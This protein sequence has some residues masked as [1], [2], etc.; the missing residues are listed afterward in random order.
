MA[1]ISAGYS[2]GATE[3]VTAAKLG[4]LA[5]SV[6]GTMTVTGINTAD[7]TDSAIT[8]GKISSVAGS[9]FIS[10][11]GVPA[12]SGVIPAA[13]LTSVAQKGA[14]SDITSLSGLT[15]PLSVAQG[16]TAST[17]AADARTALGLAI[18]TDIPSYS[19]ATKKQ[20][21]TASGTFTAPAGVI[22]V[23]L[24]MTGSGGGGG[25]G[26]NASAYEGGGGGGG[27]E[28]VVKY[29]YTV[30]PTSA[31]TVTVGDAGTGGAA[32]TDGIAGGS[33]VF[34]T[35]TMK[36]GGKGLKSG[37]AGGTGAT[38]TLNGGSPTT[39]GIGTFAG[40]NGGTGNNPNGGG[41]GGSMLG[42]GGAGGGTG[43]VGA[44]GTGCGSGGGGGGYNAAGGNG[45][46]GVVLV[47][48]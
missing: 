8:D 43:A 33:V 44:V 34:D 36:G 39:G 23:Y 15:T 40:G 18:G 20:L 4:K 45:S 48:W 1:V 5:S 46:K 41:G 3:E 10:L 38:S 32:V 17:S 35:L 31:Y 6:T 47:E 9:K 24:T 16:G 37:G 21:F 2:F 30:V 19:D 42:L 28:S 22:K 29:P 14:N 7:I 26:K 11:S 27:G 13:N 25:G 12:G